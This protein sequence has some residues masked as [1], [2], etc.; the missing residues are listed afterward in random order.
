MVDREL[1]L[2]APLLCLILVIMIG[3]LMGLN[4]VGVF[5]FLTK[6]HLDHIASVDLALA[7]RTAE[8]EARLAIQTE[9]VADLDRRIAQIDAAI[10]ESTRL[11]RPVGAMT[12]ADQ[13]R[14]DRADI[15][16]NRQRE[17]QA[18][19]ALRIEK[20]KTDVDRRR[21]EADVGPVRYLAELIGMPAT[22]LERSV[23]L[24][25]L[26]LVAVLDPM[27]VALLLAAGAHS[28]SATFR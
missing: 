5:G 6:A 21:A 3:V 15:V 16:V 12:I 8:T 25:T 27:A 28:K 26:A 19:A 18:L 22:D 20:I 2:G 1:A 17:T 23:R 14:R 9:T 7:D 4:A 11:G 24:L 13:K 10:E